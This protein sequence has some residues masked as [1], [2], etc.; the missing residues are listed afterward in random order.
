MLG[1][2]K[3]E[4]ENWMAPGISLM[5]S[6]ALVSISWII[7]AIFNDTLNVIKWSG[8]TVF[9]LTIIFAVFISTWIWY[10]DCMEWM[11]VNEILD[12]VS[13]VD[14]YV[15]AP[16]KPIDLIM[17][18][19]GK[20][21]TIG[22]LLLLSMRIS[23]ILIEYHPLLGAIILG[24]LCVTAFLFYA[25][26]FLKLITYCYRYNRF[27]MFLGVCMFAMILDGTALNIIV[28]GFPT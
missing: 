8:P 26:V 17:T 28:R 7:A 18:H 4:P 19:Y 9:Y 12:K 14:E 27:Y 22:V 3:I 15:V 23:Q 2:E 1:Q 20:V 16:Q 11:N 13:D 21:G 25:L 6:M 10:L 5:G 24:C